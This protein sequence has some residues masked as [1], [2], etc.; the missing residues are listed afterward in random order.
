MSSVKGILIVALLC[1]MLLYKAAFAV[2]EAVVDL[3]QPEVTTVIAGE[4]LSFVVELLVQGQFSGPTYFSLPRIDGAIIMQVSERPV[5]STRQINDDSYVSARYDFAVFAQQAGRMHIPSITARFGSK[6]SFDQ[7]INEYRLQTKPFNIKVTAP[8]GVA[9][10][11]V[12]VSTNALSATETWSPKPVDAKVGDA[13]TRTI[14]VHA[15]DVPAML[16][17]PPN[18]G[19]P[20]GFAIYPKS[21]RTRDRTERGELVGE[22]IDKVTY[23]STR[24]GS[25][26]IPELTLRWWDPSKEQWQ[27]QTFPAHLLT[28]ADNPALAAPSVSVSYFIKSIADI[29]SWM[30]WLVFMIISA[31]VILFSSRWLRRGW[32][33]WR[34]RRAAS[35]A[36]QWQRL[37]QICN[38]G[39]A[40]EVYRELGR[41]LT[42]YNMST[43][44]LTAT[45]SE[46]VSDS[47]RA[48]CI[49]LQQ[50]L[51]GI[52]SQWNAQIL[53]EELAELRRYL[54]VSADSAA[55]AFAPLNPPQ[56]MAKRKR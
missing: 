32:Q 14:T 45:V 27:T 22:R 3:H 2:D 11:E 12:V 37:R 29:T 48:T 4:R 24:A 15:H 16:L 44:Q 34:A 19:D 38:H 21:K 35:E 56:A 25:F 8:P 1:V 28:V 18:F 23:V 26:E 52:D 40:A 33:A 17:P 54:Q 41:W 47:L 36:L 43:S 49:Q 5:L 50:Q 30:G 9:A 10:G 7:P 13:F 20:E 55:S 31:I 46:G 53:I 39:E 42:Q 6:K 51:A